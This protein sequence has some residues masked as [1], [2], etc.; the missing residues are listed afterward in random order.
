MPDYSESNA[1]EK[2]F[3]QDMKNNIENKIVFIIFS[4]IFL[5]FF[6]KYVELG[7]RY[8]DTI[9]QMPTKMLRFGI[10]FI[11]VTIVIYC[12]CYV[13]EAI[14]SGIIF[15][16]LGLFLSIYSF[17]MSAL[18]YSFPKFSHQYMLLIVYTITGLVYFGFKY[19][20]LMTRN[21]G[22]KNK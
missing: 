2:K 6:L 11:V 15:V 16:V 13:K 17:V 10:F 9:E 12:I 8:T 3:I 7:Y 20:I 5:W 22:T 14:K 1:K 21:N 19:Y 18:K 4:S